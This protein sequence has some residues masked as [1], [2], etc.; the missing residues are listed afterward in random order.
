MKATLEKPGITA[1]CSRPRASHD[2]P[3]PEALF[4]TCKYRPD[5]PTGGF[6]TKADAQRGVQGFATRYNAEP[7]HSKVRFVTPNMRHSGPEGAI[8]AKRASLHA[9]ARA[10]NPA[11]W[12]RKVRNRQPIGAVRLNPER[13]QTVSEM[14]DAA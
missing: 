12:P 8:L 4:R 9:N 1:S 6:A 14:R 2:N 10:E 5:W 7:L 11:G 3:F 13:D